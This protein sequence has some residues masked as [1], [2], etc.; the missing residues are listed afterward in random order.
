MITL[1]SLY[2]E[3]EEV[4]NHCAWRMVHQF[5]RDFEEM[6]GVSHIAFMRAGERWLKGNKKRPFR[7]YLREIVK[8]ELKGHCRKYSKPV[9][10]TEYETELLKQKKT[11]LSPASSLVFRDMIGSLSKEA[12]F[13]AHLFLSGPTEVLKLSG[14]E[15]ARQVRGDLRRYLL[16]IGWG[17][18]RIWKAFKELRTV[19]KEI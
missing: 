15:S 13:I 10:L 8:N 3:H 4:L 16:G 2:E 18:P 1:D 19:L 11:A 5:G 17:Q 14:L 7:P 6:K 12:S 9:A